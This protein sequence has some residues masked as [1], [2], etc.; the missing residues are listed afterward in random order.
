MFSAR[1]ESR[2]QSTEVRQS[3]CIQENASG[4]LLSEQRVFGGV[5]TRDTEDSELWP[6][7]QD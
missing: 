1:N 4:L 3:W 6:K 2:C 5:V 7:K